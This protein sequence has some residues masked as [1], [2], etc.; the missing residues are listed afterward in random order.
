MN[1]KPRD[2]V[3][4]LSAGPEA[5]VVALQGEL[6]AGKTTFTQEV[7]SLLG[8]SEN[9]HSPTFVIMKIYPIEY[10]GFR[11]LVHIDAYRIERESELLHLGWE[12]MLKQPENLIFIEWPE[13]VAGIIPQQARRISFKHVNEDSREITYA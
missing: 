13:R 3:E 9:M 7:G 4:S 11:N 1:L 2:L 5:T 12:E 10:K 6:G 8:V